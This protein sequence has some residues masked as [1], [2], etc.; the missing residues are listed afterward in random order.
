MEI[1]YN[2]FYF[3]LWIWAA[4]ALVLVKGEH[5]GAP[6]RLISIP[7]NVSYQKSMLLPVWKYYR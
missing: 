2:I 6:Q 7:H 5:I 1:V 3:H 4:V